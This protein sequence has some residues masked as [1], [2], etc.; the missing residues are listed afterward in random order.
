M[1]KVLIIKK[2]L[3]VSIWISSGLFMMWIFVAYRPFFI[4]ENMDAAAFVFLTVLCGCV[5][6]LA[7]LI[8]WFSLLSNPKGSTNI[9]VIFLVVHTF[10]WGIG[11]VLLCLLSN[12]GRHGVEDKAFL[13]FLIPVATSSLA[14]RKIFAYTEP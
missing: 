4:D 14:L 10:I 7:S 2:R 5:F 9:I 6:A 11:H 3:R 8:I 12:F 13:L 1:D